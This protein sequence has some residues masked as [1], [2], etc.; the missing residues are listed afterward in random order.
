MGDDAV[1]LSSIHGAKGLEWPVVILAGLTPITHGWSSVGYYAPEG[2]LILQVKRDNDD[3]LRSAANAALIDAAKQRGEAEGRRL[4]YVGMTRAREKLILTSSYAYGEP[5]YEPD[6]LNKPIGWFAGALG[7]Y[8][9]LPEG[10]VKRFG[11]SAVRVE[12]FSPERI[13]PMRNAVAQQHD[14]VLAAARLAVRDGRPVQWNSPN[15][16]GADV[17]AIVSRVTS[18]AATNE[19]RG[20]LALTTV[21]QL[22]HFFKCPLIHYF[23]LVLKVEE[24]HGGEVRRVDRQATHDRTRARHS[25]PRAARTRRLHRCA[26]RRIDTSRE[27]T[28]RRSA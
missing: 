16:S 6:Q 13:A 5:K 22:V 24:H 25:G 3:P 2:A 26:A 4:L 8:G 12:C 10:E 7:I 19:P 28:R 1:V 27:S 11:G 17:D 15:G 23:S 21:T 18:R 20:T 14:A 9:P